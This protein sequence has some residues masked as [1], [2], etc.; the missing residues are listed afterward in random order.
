LRGL[1]TA[2]ALI[3]LIGVLAAA[4]V[5]WRPTEA[6][7]DPYRELVARWSV[8]EVKGDQAFVGLGMFVYRQNWQG[9]AQTF[10]GPVL[11]QV[12]ETQAPVRVQFSGEVAVGRSGEVELRTGAPATPAATP[13][14]AEAIL[15]AG[16][17]VALPAGTGFS[18]RTG[19][20]E[21]VRLMA[22]AILPKGP[23][24]TPGIEHAEWRTWGIVKPVPETPLVV[25]LSNLELGGG[26]GYQFRRDRGPA[27]LYVQ[28]L[29]DGAQ[30]IALTVT[31]GRGA[32]QRVTDLAP[33]ELTEPVSYT[34]PQTPTTLNRERT[35]EARAGV[36]L[37][38]GTQGRVR[39]RS[40]VDGTGVLMVTF[41]GPRAV[42]PAPVPTDVRPTPRPTVTP[43]GTRPAS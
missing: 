34:A 25:T 12:T 11:L 19:D 8:G 4:V 26:E 35:F 33:W 31:K 23:P 16:D 13:V 5:R 32:Y 30:S 38:A 43:T 21:V 6:V 17:L 29:G 27:L 3:I 39:N 28:G 22:I 36:F 40:L 18:V 7:N 24:S 9:P 20:G 42:T 1:I 14:A 15:S 2:A 10:A 41:D 37:P